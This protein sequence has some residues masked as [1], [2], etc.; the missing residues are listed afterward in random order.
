M[1]RGGWGQKSNTGKIPI[2]F[3]AVA[4]LPRRFILKKRG[5]RKQPASKMRRRKKIVYST[6]EPSNKIIKKKCLL[7][8]TVDMK[9]E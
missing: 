2:F 4:Y 7:F 1:K 5:N 6:I 9:N 3:F 8:D